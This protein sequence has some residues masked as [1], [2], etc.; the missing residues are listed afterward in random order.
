ME[1]HDT[2]V[3]H[4]GPGGRVLLWYRAHNDSHLPVRQTLQ[5]VQCD[6]KCV[7]VQYKCTM[8]L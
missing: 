2:P 8:Y 6:T 4:L 7:T 5:Y 3:P 1:D